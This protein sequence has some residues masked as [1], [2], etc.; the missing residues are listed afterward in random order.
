MNHGTE[1]DLK[2]QERIR[3]G[4]WG[5]EVEMANTENKCKALSQSHFKKYSISYL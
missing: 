3:D 5:V 2:A 4:L 1:L